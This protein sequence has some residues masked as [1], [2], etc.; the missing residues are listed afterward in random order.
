MEEWSDKSPSLVRKIGKFEWNSQITIYR[1]FQNSGK[2]FYML[3]EANLMCLD[4]IDVIKCEVNSGK[5]LGKTICIN[6]SNMVEVA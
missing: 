5:K 6:C 3:M 2:V 4:L 1:S